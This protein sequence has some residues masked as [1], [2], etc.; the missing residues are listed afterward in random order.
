MWSGTDT[1]GDCG[2][3]GPAARQYGAIRNMREMLKLAAAAGLSAFC[4][5][6]LCQ[7][8]FAV[9]D[10]SG[11]AAVISVK[12]VPG[13]AAASPAEDIR[14]VPMI[15]VWGG[16]SG[17]PGAEWSFLKEA[18]SSKDEDTLKLVLPELD[19]WL[20]RYPSYSAAP[21]AQMLKAMIHEELG[22][23]RFALV[24][25]L[26]YF[27]LYPGADGAAEARKF[28]EGILAKKG[29]K[30]T[31]AALED[32]SSAPAT[33]APDFN[34]A[35]LLK[36]L[37][38]RAG[39]AYYKPLLKEYRYF[40]DRFPDYPGNDVLRMSLA[41]LD[42]LN[43][44]FLAASLVYEEMA[45]LY[46]SS[47]L[48]AAAKLALADTL[49]YKLK[50]YDRAID[51]YED[52]AASFPG[53][54]EAWASYQRLPELAEKRKKYDLAV[55]TYEKIIA[56]YP[57]KPEAY[58]AYVSEARVLRDKLDK[59]QE[60]V[61]A[62][63]RLA[64]NYKDGRGL[65]ALE[66]AAKIYRKDL[67]N[68]DGEVKMYDRIA[69]DYSASPEAPKALYQAGELFYEQKNS[70]KANWY[71]HK[72]MDLYPGSGEFRKAAGRV[73]RIAAGKF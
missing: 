62:L 12:T 36:K 58:K 61:D 65:N 2:R 34:L 26:K 70:G 43:G 17:G 37:S 15:P 50:K 52:I 30:R 14:S 18:G 6:A 28:F 51:V 29:D 69:S 31:R 49:S 57:Q 60:A 1:L 4:C 21:D 48:M 47:P 32:A 39:E 66:L 19:D 3:A 24:D 44:R 56:L 73:A 45:K 67:K 46:P 8:A 16:H 7:R 23:H 59:Y 35:G 71:F 5:A 64:D 27:Q 22:C 40:F 25:L 72:I 38:E 53:T 33:A 41:S 42:E 55:R 54:G 63:N 11:V 9:S 68:S 10:G 13:N 20:D